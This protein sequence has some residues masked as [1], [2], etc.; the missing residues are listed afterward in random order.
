MT[1]PSNSALLK[2]VTK[3]LILLVIAKAISLSAL[4]FLPSDGVE[5]NKKENYQPKYQKVDFKGMLIQTKT[6]AQFNEDG[7]PIG[8]NN[9]TAVSITNMI[10]KGLYG[11]D[12]KGFVIVALKSSPKKTEIVEV[13]EVYSGFKLK[14]IKIAHA[15][16]TKASKEFILELQKVK[17]IGNYIKKANDQPIVYATDTGVS[18]DDI[19]YYSKNPKQLWK[20]IAI[21]EVKNG[22]KIEGF[23]VTRIDPISKMARLGLEKGDVIIKAN[24]VELKSYKDALDIYKNIDKIDVV[25]LVVIRDNQEK[26]LVYEIH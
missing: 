6:A 24:N 25:Q 8:S 3:L 18:R 7:T 9:G 16:F 17:D 26:E 19:A 21:K 12:T 1:K 15:V 20:D 5:V 2:I 10:L 23:K 22:K 4:W 11:N 13:G 14:S